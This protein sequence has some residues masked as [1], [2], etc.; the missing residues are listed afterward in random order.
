M[1]YVLSVWLPIEILILRRRF[2]DLA[3]VVRFCLRGWLL[4]AAGDGA[5]LAGQR[6]PRRQC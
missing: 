5:I 3:K 2:S 4:A 1:T 6:E